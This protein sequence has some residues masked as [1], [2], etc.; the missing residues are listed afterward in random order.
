VL[1]WA[2]YEGAVSY[3]FDDSQPSQIQHWPEIKATGVRAT[4]YLAMTYG[5]GSAYEAA[6]KDV[7][8]AGHELGDHTVHH[9]HVSELAGVY[10]GLSDEEAAA[11]E[12]DD[13]DN[14]IERV[15]GQ[16][17]VWTM[18][19]P[20]GDASWEPFLGDRYLFARTVSLGKVSPDSG[21]DPLLLP[22]YMV[23]AGDTRAVFNAK[24]DAAAAARCWQTLLFHSLTPTASNWYA[25]VRIEEV[26]ASIE[27]GKAGGRVWLDS[28]V[29]VGSYWI[30]SRLI[31][32]AV[33]TQRGGTETWSWKLPRNF[34]PGKYIRVRIGGG[35]LSQG[36][37][38]LPWIEHGFYEVALDPQ[39]LDWRP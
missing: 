8:A 23:R 20:Y 3:T 4:W 22:T 21:L 33:P 36:G 7:L 16:D 29:N 6:W 30:G 11:K 17:G 26:V 27:H 34:P 25:G 39:S 10:P 1:D 14:Y 13:C 19:Y 35:T 2:G 38:D 31:R 24:I 37:T 15:I 9:L 28:V 12:L 32:S 18:A 5:S